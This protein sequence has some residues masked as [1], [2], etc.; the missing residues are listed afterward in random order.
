M[1]SWAMHEA[2]ASSWHRSPQRSFDVSSVWK[3]VGNWARVLLPE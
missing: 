3:R 2:E 1:L